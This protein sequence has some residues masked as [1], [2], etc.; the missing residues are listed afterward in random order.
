MK[1]SHVSLVARDADRL[2][3][4]YTRIFG[5]TERRPP[6]TLAGAAVSRGNGV[7]GSEIYAI[8]LTLPGTDGPFLEIHQYR[9]LQERPLPAVN[10]PGYGHLSFAVPDI[11]ATLAAILAAGGTPL[12]EITNFGTATAPILL[13]Y[14]RDP[15]GNVLEL[16]QG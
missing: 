7:P 3:D 10:Q 15:E 13:V 8:W 4:F 14:V 5:C 9:T 16:E 2:A 11:D 6:K 1:F 12:G